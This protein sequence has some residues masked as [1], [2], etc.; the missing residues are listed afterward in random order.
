MYN[1]LIYL[2]FRMAIKL[3]CLSLLLLLACYSRAKRPHCPKSAT[4]C[5]ECIRS[6]PDCAW[7]TAPDSDIRCQ[8]SKDLRRAGCPKDHIYNPQGGV[9]VA[10]NDSRYQTL[11]RAGH[12]MATLKVV[13]S[14]LSTEPLQHGASD[15][16]VSL[17][18]ASGVICTVEARSEAVF[19]HHY[20]QA[21]KP[22][23]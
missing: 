3:H 22:A 17:P 18:P 11:V 19:L 6:G 13:I 8:T 9:Q 23:H 10:K 4:D 12:L 7:C 21:S 15:S 2:C 20:H 16:R 14:S 5:D 1:S